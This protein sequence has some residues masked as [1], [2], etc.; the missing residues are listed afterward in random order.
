MVVSGSAVGEMALHFLEKY[1]LMV[2]KMPSKFELQRF[3]R[4]TGTTARATFGAPT[5]DELGFAKSLRVQ[6]GGWGTP[7]WGTGGLHGC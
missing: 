1:G 5:A 2:I 7:V 4:A 6:V 3:C